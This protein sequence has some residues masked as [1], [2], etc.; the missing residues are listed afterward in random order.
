MLSFPLSRSFFSEIISASLFIVGSIVSL[1][2][3]AR[4]SLLCTSADPSSGECLTA[5]NKMYFIIY[6]FFPKIC[7][8]LHFFFVAEICHLKLELGNTLLKVARVV[9]LLL[10][11]VLILYLGLSLL[12][13]I[14]YSETNYSRKIYT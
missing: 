10:K 7:P 4:L 5:K 12:Y 13:T 9:L 11:S 2:S 8:N 1:P 3:F 6:H 14:L